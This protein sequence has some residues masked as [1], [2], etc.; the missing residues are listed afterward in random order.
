MSSNKKQ[1]YVQQQITALPELDI[2]S[3]NLLQTS[4]VGDQ[5]IIFYPI[6]PLQD[7]QIITF[8]VPESYTGVIM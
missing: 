8:D 3:T 2:F 4:V 5:A 1:K 7:G 6:A